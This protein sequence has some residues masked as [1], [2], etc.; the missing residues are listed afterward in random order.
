MERLAHISRLRNS[1][2]SNHVIAIVL[3]LSML[4]QAGLFTPAPVMAQGSTFPASPF[5]GMQITYSMGG[6]TITESK[7]SEGFTVSRSLKG[8]LGSGQLTLSGTVS[9]A[10]GWGAD[11]TARV[12]VGN[13]SKEFKASLV[14]PKNGADTKSFSLAVP[15]PQG[16]TSGG[17]SINM[18]GSY[19]AG[20]R[21]LVVS[22][23]FGAS[24]SSAP[25][26]STP[27]VVTGAQAPGPLVDK[28]P[29]LIAD[30][31]T[32]YIDKA[33]GNPYYV[34]ADPPEV[35]PSQRKWVKIVPQ[36]AVRRLA[37]GEH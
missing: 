35:P 28:L 24:A 32:A 22:G 29:T 17:F 30:N 12:W 2:S 4:W 6:A 31:T 10:M 26:V 11:A 1:I 20:S 16:A 5:N 9:Q 8:T 18:N 15:I 13:D 3:A 19:N 37:L 34:S 14:T 36:R 25:A 27:A 21:G 33:Q 23:S 7:D